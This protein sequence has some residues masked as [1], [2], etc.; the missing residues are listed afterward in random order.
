MLQNPVELR[1]KILIEPAL[2]GADKLRIIS[3]YAA[4][5]MVSW[6]IS[7]LWSITAEKILILI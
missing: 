6:H 3:G 5:T 1:N 4:H 2:N 7:E